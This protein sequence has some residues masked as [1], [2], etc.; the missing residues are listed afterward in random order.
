MHFWYLVGHLSV[1]ILT[2]HNFYLYYS[3]FSCTFPHRKVD[4]VISQ[5]LGSPV[6]DKLEAE[7]A[8][9]A[10][11]LPAT[12]GFQFGSGFAG[13][14][15]CLFIHLS[16]FVYDFD[17]LNR[18]QLNNVIFLITYIWGVFWW[19]SEIIIGTF[20]TGSEHND[21]FYIDEHGNTRTRTNRS[22]G[23]QVF[24]LFYNY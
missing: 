22:G 6:F 3:D 24:V 21:E 5:G 10:M 7:L 2:P 8:K 11:S 17:W 1:L 14:K 4:I 23:I 19:L 12:K 13:T 18:D 15:T 16:A 9:A 20:L